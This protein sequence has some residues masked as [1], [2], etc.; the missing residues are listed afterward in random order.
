LNDPILE[1][2]RMFAG[3]SVEKGYGSVASFV[4]PAL[5]RKPEQIIDPNWCWFSLIDP[6]G[7]A[8]FRSAL[9][10]AATHGTI[11]VY[12]DSSYAHDR[13]AEILVEHDSLMFRAKGNELEPVLRNKCRLG[14]LL[15]AYAATDF[16]SL[17]E[18]L[19]AIDDYHWVD[20]YIGAHVAKGD[21]D[22]NELYK[23]VLSPFNDWLK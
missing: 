18:R 19:R 14:V 22:I 9:T 11:Y 23:N 8:K 4:N 17:A 21:V 6:P 5:K 1:L 3:F 15:S 10:A 20:L 2:D 16:A 7:A 12:V 13:E